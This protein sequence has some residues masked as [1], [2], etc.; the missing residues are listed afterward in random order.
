M[1]GTDVIAR[2]G[3]I[4]ALLLL[5]FNLVACGGG[6]GSS[7]SPGPPAPSSLKYTSPVV[8]VV[9]SA[10]A[11]LS[12][13]VTG[14]VTAYA[15]AP[16]LPAGLALDTH[17]GA[18]SGTPSAVSGTANYTVTASNAS[19]STTFSISIT[20]NDLA[21]SISY[22]ATQVSFEANA[23]IA[24]LVPTNHGGAAVSWAI[25]TPLSSGLTFDSSDGSISG[26][27]TGGLS[28]AT[29]VIT[30]TNSG[31]QSSFSLT[32]AV[33]TVLLELG[34]ANEIGSVATT[35]SKALSVD[36]TGHWVVWDYATGAIVASGRNVGPPQLAASIAVEIISSAIIVRDANDWRQLSTIAGSYNWVNVAADGSYLCAGNQSG[37]KA[38]SPAGAELLSKSGDYSSAFAFAALD[39]IQVARGPAGN[40]VVEI[41]SIADGS[42]VS[43]PTFQGDFHAWF[44]DGHRFLSVLGTTVWTYSRNA[45]QEDVRVLPTVAFLRGYGNWFWVTPNSARVDIYA[46]GASAAPTAS[47]LTGTSSMIVPSGGTIGVLPYGQG[48]VS[49]IDLD[50]TTPTETDHAVPIPYLTQYAATTASNWLV[51]NKHGVLLDGASLAGTPRYL[52]LGAA[53]SIAGSDNRIAVATAAGTIFYYDAHSHALEGTIQSYASQLALSADG[54]VL[55][56]GV[57]PRLD[58]QFHDDLTVRTL[59]LPAGTEIHAWPYS[60]ASPPRQ[61]DL[62]LSGSGTALGQILQSISGS[63]TFAR[64][65]TDVTGT[66]TL[67]SDSVTSTYFLGGVWPP[68]RLSP[69]GSLVAAPNDTPS[70][71]VVTNI[72]RNGSLTTA[73]PGSAVGWIDDNRLLVQT[74]KSD[75]SSTPVYDSSVLYDSTGTKLATPTLPVLKSIQTA[76]PDA[77]YAPDLNTIYSLSTGAKAWSSVRPSTGVGALAGSQVV[78]GSG[79]QVILEPY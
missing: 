31:G 79:S 29:Y 44:S 77:I 43:S 21:P 76:S 4:A 8:L 42:A 19:G 3:R 61:F 20:V 56:T 71:S 65:V 72:F 63:S 53:V 34:H 6:G 68:I 73:I 24:K 45:V 11:P 32:I 16:T 51:G 33:D 38:W 17:S 27:P 37:V 55:A 14:T 52:S 28:P 41:I 46:V 13:T 5:V 64:Q 75:N 47:F 57:N 2:S 12:P 48:L 40:D 7:G 49:V 60:F 39:A 25:D 15:V 62:T 54:S 9:G 10:M 69:D 70:K 35:G 66:T 50:G 36:E 23:P 26:T 78:F 22:P 30:A 18:V 59:S 58:S 1:A 67:W 74:Y